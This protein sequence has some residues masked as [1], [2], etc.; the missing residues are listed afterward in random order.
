MLNGMETNF[1]QKVIDI[2]PISMLFVTKSYS[3]FF[4]KIK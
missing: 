1:R 3:I 2:N 4:R